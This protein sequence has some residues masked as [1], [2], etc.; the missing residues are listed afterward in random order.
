MPL[1]AVAGLSLVMPRGMTSA[2][3]PAKSALAFGSEV[4]TPRR[5]VEVYIKVESAA[6]SPPE[7]NWM[8]RSG[9]AAP[10]ERAE[11]RMS[12]HAPA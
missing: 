10:P 6:K 2:S 8:P 3:V 1:A 5:P 4:P 11:V 9:L 7:L 12:C